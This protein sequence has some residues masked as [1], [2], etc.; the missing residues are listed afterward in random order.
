M[1]GTFFEREREPQKNWSHTSFSQ[2]YSTMKDLTILKGMCDGMGIQGRESFQQSSANPHLEP[3][4]GVVGHSIDRYIC[5]GP[6]C[7][8]RH[9]VLHTHMQSRIV[10]LEPHTKQKKVQ[11]HTHL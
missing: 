11:L 6:V 4:V 9:A 1:N 2:W 7:K 3:H 8:G 5:H 10:F